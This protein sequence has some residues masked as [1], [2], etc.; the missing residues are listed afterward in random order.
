M[1][2]P[3]PPYYAVIFT[4]RR[5]EGDR[6]YEDTAARMLELAAEMEGFLG[7]DSVREGRDGVTVC[8]DE[9]KLGPLLDRMLQTPAAGS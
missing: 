5:T 3:P 2:T 4:S 9:Q 8:Y 7:V 6:G 1:T